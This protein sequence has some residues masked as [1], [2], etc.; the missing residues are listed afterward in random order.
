[1]PSLAGFMHQR[2]VYL[3]IVTYT[4]R[5]N[6]LLMTESDESEKP[7]LAKVRLGYFFGL[8]YVVVILC[9]RLRCE[10]SRRRVSLLGPIASQDNV[11]LG[12]LHTNMV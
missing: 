7:N 2:K 1:M 11:Q 6:V 5:D 9:L 8:A 10:R 3:F 4:S 12:L